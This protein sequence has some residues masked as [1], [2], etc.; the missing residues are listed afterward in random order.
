MR[1]NSTFISRTVVV[2][3]LLIAS[4]GVSQT[5]FATGATILDVTL[6]TA[7]VAP[8]AGF[9]IPVT[10]GTQDGSHNVASVS[11]V[12]TYDP[13]VVEI[14]SFSA[15]VGWFGAGDFANKSS[16]TI[17][18]GGINASG[19]AGTVAFGTLGLTAVGPGGTSTALTIEPL[20]LADNTDS[21]LVTQVI[22]GTLTNGSVSIIPQPTFSVA[23]VSVT[24][25]AG[26]LNFEITMDPPST[27]IATI[28]YSTTAGTATSSGPGQDYGASEVTGTATV[29]ANTSSTT[30]SI[31]ISPDSLDEL[32]ETFVVTISNNPAGSGIGQATATVTI[33][34]DDAAP[35]LIPS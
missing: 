11:I 22:E 29:T 8:G 20:I 26:T 14:D 5:A 2:L 13:G 9:S 27:T 7:S 10:L 25:S 21:S 34:D 16:G 1:R 12:V 19:E 23:D 15:P 6:G 35:S 24:E 3:A 32:D 30:F 33:L 17:S 18:F 31:P 28:N 4:F